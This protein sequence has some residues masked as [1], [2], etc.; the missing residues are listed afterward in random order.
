MPKFKGLRSV[1][2]ALWKPYHDAMYGQIYSSW[3]D[4]PIRFQPNEWFGDA[5]SRQ[6]TWGDTIY[7][8]STFAGKRSVKDDIE[9]RF[10][11]FE[12]MDELSL[13]NAE[14]SEKQRAYI[15]DF[16]E[17]T[18]QKRTSSAPNVT[19][20]R[21]DD[22]EDDDYFLRSDYQYA[23][24][25]ESTP[26]VVEFKK[27][28]DQGYFR[29]EH[30]RLLKEGRYDLLGL[31]WVEAEK[32]GISLASSEFGSPYTYSPAYV[33]PIIDTIKR[34]QQADKWWEKYIASASSGPT[35]TPRRLIKDISRRDTNA[36]PGSI[37][38]PIRVW[39]RPPRPSRRAK[40]L[41]TQL[42]PATDPD[43]E[44]VNPQPL[45]FEEF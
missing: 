4:P 21:A 10:N 25:G 11:R 26:A 40:R 14:N 29:E 18:T 24:P 8:E 23:R 41:S 38:N 17:E 22:N 1:R 28:G 30:K 33:P 36:P 19:E 15:K 43:K 31:L 27:F 20:Q 39:N 44:K 3:D 2:K 42:Y 6:F 37:L 32:H 7:T 34:T 12:I 35:P 45:D 16:V 13:F 5:L 9:K